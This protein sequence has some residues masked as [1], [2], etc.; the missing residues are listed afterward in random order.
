MDK[1]MGELLDNSILEVKDEI[2]EKERELYELYNE[3]YDIDGV[4]DDKNDF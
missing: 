2:M 3:F 4:I 1:E